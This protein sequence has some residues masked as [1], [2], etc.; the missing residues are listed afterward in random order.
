[1]LSVIKSLSRRSPKSF[2]LSKIK[3]LRFQSTCSEGMGPSIVQLKE[4]IHLELGGEL[5]NVEIL[6]EEFGP[7]DKNAPVVYIMPA[8]SSGA[9]VTCSVSD[10]TPGWWQDM[11]GPNKCIDT[12]KYRVICSAIL[13]SPFGSTS[14]LSIN[15][16]TNKKYGLTFPAI[17]PGDQATCHKL[18]LDKLG[19]TAPLHTLIGSSLGGM[20]ALK[21]AAHFPGRAERVI[22]ICSTGKT[23]PSTAAFRRV[24]RAAIMADPKFKGGHYHEDD[25]PTHGLSV[26]RELGTITYRSLDEFNDRFD[27]YPFQPFNA[28]GISFEVEQY[29]QAQGQRF[30]KVYD[31]NC[32]MVLSKCMDYMDL[33]LG[34]KNYAEGVSRIESKLYLIAID[35]DMLIPPNQLEHLSVLLHAMGKN[36]KFETLSSHYGHDAFLKETEWFTEKISKFMNDA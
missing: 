24:Q 16:K 6:Y 30:S 33:G 3:Y 21:F 35:R 18:L 25:P 28:T 12:N 8:L 15:P 31:A 9:H 2:Q 10:P 5:D 1:M 11:V 27:W 32:Y 29:L 19:I 17:T 14:P 20:Q 34:C 7:K 22:S 13:G 4:P 26:A 36:T 23:S